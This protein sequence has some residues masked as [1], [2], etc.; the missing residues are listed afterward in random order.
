MDYS[1]VASLSYTLRG[2]MWPAE[3]FLSSTVR[4]GVRNVK[5]WVPLAE[6]VGYQH[7][8]S[9]FLTSYIAKWE[10]AQYAARTDWMY[11][12][13]QEGID[14]IAARGGF[15]ILSHP[16]GPWR[17]FASLVR[18]RGVE[19]YSAFAEHQ[20]TASTDTFYTRTNRNLDLT[21]AWDSSLSSGAFVVGVAVNDH[22]G[23]YSRQTGLTPRVR[24]SGKLLVLTDQATLSGFRQAMYRGSVFAVRDFSLRKDG[25]PRVDSIWVRRDSIHVATKEAVVWL[26]DGIRQASTQHALAVSSLPLSSKYVRL[27]ISNSE[28]STVYTQPFLLRRKGDVN[29]DWVVNSADSET[30]KAVSAGKDTVRV[31]RM[32]CGDR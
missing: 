10:P 11:G 22:Y 6:E 13:A 27:E 3:S 24:D 12:S 16:W 14:L 23:P 1:G 29:G 9:L 8:S 21:A 20:F 19:V 2:R 15:P 4:Q 5:A 25:Y 26:V 32:A 30:C 18:Y 31:H 7:L 28:R 17:T